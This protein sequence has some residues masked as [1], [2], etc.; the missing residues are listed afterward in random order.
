MTEPCNSPHSAQLGGWSVKTSCRT[1]T[2]CS[3]RLGSPMHPHL[4]HFDFTRATTDPCDLCAASASALLAL[5]VAMS[6]CDQL[7]GSGAEWK[8]VFR[9]MAH[10]LC[11][12]LSGRLLDHPPGSIRRPP[13]RL[14][15]SSPSSVSSVS[16]GAQVS[17]TTTTPCAT[18]TGRLGGYRRR[19][20]PRPE[21]L[22]SRSAARC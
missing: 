11:D 21:L 14:T 20:G 15:S 18:A 8:A 3:P 2:R 5:C 16:G 12:G 9:C 6:T 13:P 19:P 10:A 17:A 1:G 7:P 4:F 22:R